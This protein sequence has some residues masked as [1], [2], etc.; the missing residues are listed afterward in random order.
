MK[1]LG[2]RAQEARGATEHGMSSGWANSSGGR[3][4][5]CADRMACFCFLVQPGDIGSAEN[6]GYVGTL[7]LPPQG[8]PGDG[9]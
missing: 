5:V 4:S 3:C 2:V 7:A 6:D 8:V 1:S 9:D